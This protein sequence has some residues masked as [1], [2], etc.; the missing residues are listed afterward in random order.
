M[1]RVL[2]DKIYIYMVQFKR[3]RH[4]PK[5]PFTKGFKLTTV[6]LENREYQDRAVNRTLALFKEGFKNLLLESPTGSGKTIMGL[7]VAKHFEDT[8]GWRT[9]WVAMRRNLLTQVREANDRFFGLKNLT[10]VSMF[11]KEPPQAELTVIDEGH[12]DA[13]ASANHIHD[14][15]GSKFILGLSATPFRTDKMK[16]SFQKTVKDAGIYALIREGFLSPFKHWM[17]QEYTPDKVAATYLDDP[18]KWGKSV[19]FFHTLTQCGRFT[20]LLREK[21]VRADVVSSAEGFQSR[22][23]KLDRFEAGELDVIANVAILTEGFDCPEIRTIFVRDSAKIVTIQ[24]A[25]RGLR[26]APGKDFCNIVQSEK[27][28]WPFTKTAGPMASNV[29]RGDDWMTLSGNND[30]LDRASAATLNNLA[31]SKK[32]SILPDFLLNRQPK[33]IGAHTIERRESHSGRI[34]DGLEVG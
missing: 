13:C 5:S 3:S 27:S 14:K 11:E 24:M 2:L 28:P 9:N 34:K 15:S 32:V 29:R 25:G 23:E 10:P 16:L 17:I 20:E 12:H 18:E 8:Y 4:P 7:R 22:E 26:R 1:G 21:G 6:V 31:N 33:R 19:A 30:I